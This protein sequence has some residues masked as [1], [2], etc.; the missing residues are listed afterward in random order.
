MVL[1]FAA[2]ARAVEPYEPNVA[3][4]LLESWRWQHIEQLD[5]L[6]FQC[7]TQD[8]N[9][10]MW[11]G[12]M[13]GVLRYDGQQLRHFHRRSALTQNVQSILTTKDGCLYALTANNIHQFMD[14][15][16][17]TLLG[18]GYGYAYPPGQALAEDSSGTVWAA[19]RK[20]LGRIR[21]REA[22]LYQVVDGGITT[23]FV[24]SADRLWWLSADGSEFRVVP[25]HQ[26]QFGP[27]AQGRTFPLYPKN[28]RRKTCI[29]QTRDGRIWI[30]SNLAD[31]PLHIYDPRADTW[32]HLDPDSPGGHFACTSML[33]ARDGALWMIGSGRLRTLKDGRWKV[34]NTLPVRLSSLQAALL[35]TA[36]GILW[37][38][39]VSGRVFRIDHSDRKCLSYHG[40]HF[41]CEN[42]IGRRWF[43]TEA[44]TV[45]SQSM[46]GDVWEQYD[47]RDNLIDTPVVI[48]AT[49]DG[50]VWAAGSH[51]GYAAVSRFDGTRWDRRVFAEM[52]FGI[53]LSLA[54]E[55]VQLH[56]GTIAAVSPANPE[57]VEHPG[58]QI[59][60][61][62][63]SGAVPSRHPDRQIPAE[64]AESPQVVTAKDD[65]DKK[66][67]VLL[68]EDNEDMRLYVV[69]ILTGDYRLVEA[70]DGR[71]AMTRAQEAW[72]DLIVS[73]IMMPKMDGLELC[74]ALKTDEN[75]S[76]IPVILLTAKGSEEAQVTGLETGAD[77]Y[78]T[79]PF[80]SAVLLARVSNL[81][82]SRRRL[83][84][85][86]SRAKIL[87][88]REITVTSADERFLQKAMDVLEENMGDYEFD[89]DAFT[90]M[91]PVSQ[92][93]LYRKIK[94]LTGQS[95]SVFIRSIR[96]NRAAALLEAGKLNVSEAA[97]QA[98]FLDMSYFG[99]CFK[100]QFQCTPSQYLSEHCPQGEAT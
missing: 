34:Y 27:T 89:I 12:L 15:R 1:I 36:D 58:T 46:D 93:S 2:S 82:E 47:Q 5:G 72:P 17:Q 26:G 33:Q 25:L 10:V 21:D 32:T 69:S 90:R 71:E 87:D 40:L 30:G 94:A 20:G 45:V 41:Q 83:R 96:L 7:M 54:K 16:W 67:T 9:G 99:K 63:P 88:P 97:Y 42:A 35:E 64:P 61:Q 19:T 75:T 13:N 53:G 28:S 80:S 48:I 43:L 77:D 38:G 51:T 37:V 18:V 11:F 68:V 60:V 4:P 14:D 55:L 23:V 73:D 76:H 92:S 39:E 86:F 8:A 74:R 70:K 100:D 91:M 24:D 31:D 44:G 3:D 81:L 29:I 78:I 59:T 66:P 95:P 62:L 85:R 98:G 84:Q 65:P 6:S 52:C 49:R 22:E 56:S 50:S 79:K 57:S